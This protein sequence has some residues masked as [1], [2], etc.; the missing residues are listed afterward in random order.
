MFGA[1]FS[2]TFI[3]PSYFNARKIQDKAEEE[4]TAYSS[5]GKEE[6]LAL[7]NLLLQ[8]LEHPQ[9]YRNKKIVI[10]GDIQSGAMGQVSIGI[11]KNSLVA[12]EE[13]GVKPWS[14]RLLPTSETLETRTSHTRGA[15]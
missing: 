10:L 2:K 8:S 9:Q 13:T 6:M 12:P 14:A 4:M 11:Y 1:E 7:L 3:F 5:K 15:C